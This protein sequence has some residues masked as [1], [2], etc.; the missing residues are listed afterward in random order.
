MIDEKTM[1]KLLLW[2]GFTLASALALQMPS[3]AQAQGMPAITPSLQKMLAALPLADMK[4]EVQ[5]MVKTLK[6]TSCGGELKDC[7]STKSGL[8]QLYFFTSKG[9]QQTFLLVINK[10]MPMPSLLKPNVQKLMGGT[11]LSDPIISISTTDFD[12][13]M[14]KMPAELQAVVR[15]SYFNVSSLAFAS[16][17]QLAARA[18][19][20][21]VMKVTMEGLGVKADQMTLRAAVAIPIPTDLAGAAGTGAGLADALKHSDTMK[22]AGADALSPE[23][24]IEFQFAPNAKL[25][26]LLPPMDLTDATFFVDN[27]LTFGYKGN[28]YFKGVNNK[29]ILLQFQTQLSPLGVMD[30]LS[31][32][33]RM[34]TPPNLTLEDAANVMVAMASPD[35]RLAAYGGGFIGGIESLKKPL[36][37]A[38]APLSVFQLKNPQPHADYKFGDASKPFPTED[39]YF[40]IALL[41]PLAEGGPLMQLAGD[42]VILGQTM[43]S[44]NVSAGKSGFHGAVAQ[45]ISL[46]LGPL[47]KVTI[48]KMLAEAD[49]DKDTQRIRLKGN[50]GG[51]VVEIL[52]AGST[53]TINVPANCVNPF[54]IKTQLNIEATSNIASIFDGQGG[55]TVDPSKISGCIGKEL[56][57]AY[58]KIANQYK[59]TT[60]YAASAANAELKKI[61]DAS[62]AAAKKVADEA[63]AAAAA[64]KKLADD[65]A[66][67]T[68]KAYDETK[69]TARN[70]ANSSTNEANRFFKAADNAFKGLGKKKRHSKGPDPLFASSVFDWDYY[71]DNHPELVAQGIDLATYWRDTGAIAGHQG[72]NEFNVNFYRERYADVMRLCSNLQCARQHWLDIGLYQGRQGSPSFSIASYLNRYPDLRSQFG[73]GEFA[74]AFE[75]WFAF[76]IAAGRSGSP[77]PDYTGSLPGPTIAGGGDGEVLWDDF[78][79]CAE[80][81]VDGVRLRTGGSIDGAQFHYANKD[82]A[83]PHGYQGNANEAYDLEIVLPTGEYFTAVEFVA[84]GHVDS[85]LFRTSRGRTIGRY[86][87]LGGQITGSFT[88]APGQKLGCMAGRSRSSITQLVFSSTG[89]R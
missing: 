81:Y 84:G 80:S 21:G 63:A 65:A 75:D 32:S 13:D 74:G 33:F 76:G 67:A 55:V 38:V 88:V 56:E 20:G 57:A 40:N 25:P 30:L 4:G 49:I 79:Q 26:M 39:K 14:A 47:G 45:N 52:L 35:A 64:S 19:L 1:K 34:A 61:S 7:Y 28:A 73:N 59:N 5:G 29:K 9:A 41:G 72:S 31:F 71:Y 69:N 18:E 58:N 42:A 2:M 53:L 24:Y 36:L 6:Q 11:S 43:G 78:G 48:E 17:V 37:A 86:G 87:Y 8:L 70:L 15:N 62:A 22:K 46:K 82:W 44:L 51:Q 12:L 54:E 10:K 23:A 60:G 68:K 50:F 3:Q 27:S 89:P 66:A 85:L 77:N 16:G 83:A